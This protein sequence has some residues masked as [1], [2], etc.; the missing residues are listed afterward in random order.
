MQYGCE[1]I[2]PKRSNCLGRYEEGN[3][4]GL[5]RI[6]FGKGNILS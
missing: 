1:S 2:G 6:S 5:K 3:F 4:H